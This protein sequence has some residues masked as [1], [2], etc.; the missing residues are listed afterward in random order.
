MAE[1]PN[2]LFALLVELREVCDTVRPILNGNLELV[3]AIAAGVDA[4]APRFDQAIED[5]R[6]AIQAQ[7]KLLVDT[8]ASLKT[9]ATA[10]VAALE[11]VPAKAQEAGTSLDCLASGLQR[12]AQTVAEARAAYAQVVSTGVE[13]LELALEKYGQAAEGAATHLAA[14]HKTTTDELQGLTAALD[15]TRADRVEH[16]EQWAE[17]IDALAEASAEAPKALA[18]ALAEG[19]DEQASGMVASVNGAIDAYH[20]LVAPWGPVYPRFMVED[21]DPFTTAR[22]ALTRELGELGELTGQRQ[23]EVTAGE[24]TILKALVEVSP[25]LGARQEDLR[26][27]EGVNE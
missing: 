4:L 20:E 21:G 26:A 10:A 1:E 16:E 23:E 25:A 9:D 19:A 8:A 18:L 2:K 13:A 11:S 15:A 3:Q 7:T 17:A 6:E 22:D 12:A 24:L 5:L 14:A 27:V